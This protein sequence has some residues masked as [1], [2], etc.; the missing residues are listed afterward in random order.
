[1]R[2]PPL[3]FRPVDLG[4]VEAIIAR[5]YPEI[6][7]VPVDTLRCLPSG[8]VLLVDVRE[9]AEYDAGHLPGA[10]RALPSRPDA[11]LSAAREQAAGRHCIF[12]CSVGE[13]SKRFL[14]KI[15]G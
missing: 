9:A 11:W 15:S 7:H 8:E 12:Y 3:P 10:E 6:R 13:R 4:E 5:R 14:G 1:M 2:W